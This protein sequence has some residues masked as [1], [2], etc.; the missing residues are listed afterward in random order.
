[1]SKPLY[2][3]VTAVVHD[4]GDVGG[5]ADLGRITVAQ[6]EAAPSH[7]WPADAPLVYILDLWDRSGH[8]ADKFVSRE[9]AAALLGADPLT[10]DQ[11]ARQKLACIEDE[12]AESA[13]QEALLT[14]DS[15]S[16]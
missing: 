8:F 6:Y 11:I 5:F 14:P 1:M 7:E 2:A 12:S 4:Y 13:L 3:E 9:T 10:L 16:D 15:E